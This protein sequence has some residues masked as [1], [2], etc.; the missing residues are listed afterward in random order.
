L[1]ISISRFQ[2]QMIRIIAL[3][4]LLILAVLGPAMGQPDLELQDLNIFSGVGGYGQVGD[5]IYDSVMLDGRQ[6]FNVAAK[7]SQEESN[8]LGT[9]PL[10]IRINRIENRLDQL[11]EGGFFPDGKDAQ[12]VVNQLNNQMVVQAVESEGAAPISMVTVT[13]NDTEIYGLAA[14]DLAEF[15]AEQIR[16]GLTLAMA[17]RQPE[18]RLRRAA[19]GLGILCLALLLSGLFLFWQ[20]RMVQSRRR[21]QDQLRDISETLEQIDPVTTTDQDQSAQTQDL[22]AVQ[23]KLQRQISRSNTRQRSLWVAQLVLWLMSISLVMRLFPLTRTL[24]LLILRQPVWI[25]M[26]WFLVTLAVMV[27][28]F[29]TDRAL[30]W[31]VRK[32]GALSS[33]KLAR[34]QKRLP[35]LSNVLKGLETNGFI[36]LGA[37]STL[38]LLTLFSM[39]ELFASA[40]VLGLAASIAFQSAIKD[41]VTGSI[42]LWRDAYA[43]GDVI[44]INAVSGYVEHMDLLLTQLRASGGELITLRNGNIDTVRNMTKDWSRIDLTIDVAYDT[45]ADKALH[46]MGQ[47]FE[48]MANDPDWQD[49]ILEA[50]DILAIENLSYHGAT[51]KIRAKTAPMQQWNISREYRRRLKLRLTEANISIGVPQQAITVQSPTS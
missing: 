6:L 2:R 45:D 42:L 34:K 18:A 21:F 13:S 22:R 16:R 12:I 39:F 17:E 27:S 7:A 48:E 47:V 11:I 4:L 50:P 9:A 19:I 33:Q 10:D 28:H 25:V 35:T 41:A 31:W 40:G 24:G 5:L 38:Q 15:Y 43:V 51:L 44:A 20:R 14:P 37:I 49:R 1:D 3:A 8:R 46:I 26:T 23:F 29:V 30:A 36:V 32:E